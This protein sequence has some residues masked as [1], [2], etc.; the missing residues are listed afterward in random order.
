MQED[1]KVIFR[2]KGREGVIEYWEQNNCMEF[3]WEIGGGQGIV[4]IIQG[5][6]PWDWDKSNP[7]AA[8]RRD[9]ILNRVAQ[10]VIRQRTTYCVPDIHPRSG[11]FYLRQK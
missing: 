2:G 3:Y 8:N 11:I 1:W 5:P 4:L 6:E 9:E 10:E 7:W